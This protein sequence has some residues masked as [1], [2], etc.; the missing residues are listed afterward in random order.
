MEDKTKFTI[1]FGLKDVSDFE[2]FIEEILRLENKLPYSFYEFNVAGRK[3]YD[4]SFPTVTDEKEL[5]RL[6]KMVRKKDKKSSPIQ[7]LNQTLF[8]EMSHYK[9]RCV[10]LMCEND[11]LKKALSQRNKEILEIIDHEIKEEMEA[12]D[13]KVIRQTWDI[14]DE[15]RYLKQQLTNSEGKE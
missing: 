6:A 9:S 11:E 2:N 8:K 4:I 7:E 12:I 3:Q 10:D 15:L 5:K 13:K 14:V 1:T